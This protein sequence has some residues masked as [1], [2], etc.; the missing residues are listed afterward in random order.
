MTDRKNLK[1]GVHTYRLLK[2]EKRDM[3]TWD[4]M[5]RRLMHE[6]DD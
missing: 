4:A 6:A 1:I 5:F 3:E 2:D